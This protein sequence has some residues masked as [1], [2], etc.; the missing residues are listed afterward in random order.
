MLSRERVSVAEAGSEGV[1]V[2]VRARFST[3]TMERGRL[4]ERSE[5]CEVGRLCQARPLATVSVRVGDLF[6]ASIGDS[7]SLVGEVDKSGRPAMNP[8][9]GED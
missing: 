3:A 1:V 2:E 7:F 6:S 8:D 9:C 4:R 5:A